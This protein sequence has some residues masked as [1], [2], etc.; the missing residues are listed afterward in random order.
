M[1]RLVL[2]CCHPALAPEVASALALRLVV[3]V[4][5]RR[6]R[7]PLPRARADDGRA[8]HPRQAQDRRR[9]AS[10]SRCPTPSAL[11]AARRRRPDAPTSRSPPATPRAAVPTCCAPTSPG[12]AVR[13]VRVARAPAPGRAGAARPCSR[14]C[15]SSTPAATP[16]ST[17][18]AGSCCCPTRTA[19]GGTTTR[20]PRRSSCSTGCRGRVT[21]PLAE[22]YRLQALVA[23]EHATAVTA[24]DTRW[25]RICEHYAA[26]VALNPSPAV[27]L[28]AAVALAERDGPHAGLARSTTWTT[29]CRTATGCRR[30]AASCSPGPV[31]TRR[32]SRPST[33]RSPGA[34]TTSSASTSPGAATSCRRTR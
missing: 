31:R 8:A 3:G 11:R 16:A 14:C 22:S 18:T 30:C 1:L 13:L 20:S 9:P 27:R 12:E 26:L 34:A 17:P 29:R 2:M 6:H 33:W 4:T 19:R 32:P 21:S 23:A 7:P 24:S 28:A 5:D 10:R 25:D 15:S